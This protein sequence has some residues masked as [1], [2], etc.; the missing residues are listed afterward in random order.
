MVAT[1]LLVELGVGLDAYSIRLFAPK[2]YML[3]FNSD[4]VQDLILAVGSLSVGGMQLM[5][6]PWIRLLRAESNL[7]Y[8]LLALGLDG[9]LAHAWSMPTATQLLSNHCWTERFDPTTAVGSNIS[10]FCLTA[11]T[12]DLATIPKCRPL[13]ISK[14]ELMVTHAS[15]SM[16]AIFEHLQHYIRIRE[17]ADFSP[18]SS[19]SSS[20]GPSS[21]G[22][23]GQDGN[24]D[25]SFARAPGPH[26]TGPR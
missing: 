7:L 19:S 6:R 23:N 25:R 18:N 10:C 21:D 4:A 3:S 2:D 11:W 24:L 5:F 1:T 13:M 8:Y 20:G 9:V 12:H 14:S 17:I 26:A 15:P 22:D 16:E